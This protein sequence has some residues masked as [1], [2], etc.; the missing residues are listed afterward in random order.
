MDTEPREAGLT[1]RCRVEFVGTVVEERRLE[2]DVVDAAGVDFMDAYR[3][4]EAESGLEE[5]H[6]E[7][8]AR[9]CPQPAVRPI[10]DVTIL[11]VAKLRQRVGQ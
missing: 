8:K 3:L 11:I 1:E 4:I 10:P 5:G 2:L 9:F 6:L 7:R